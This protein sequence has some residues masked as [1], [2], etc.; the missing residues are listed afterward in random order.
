MYETSQGYEIALSRAK[1]AGLRIFR[2]KDFDGGF[3]V[4]SYSLT[5][6]A[7]RIIQVRSE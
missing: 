6:T 2:G 1:R 3:V 7:K 5:D 4:Q